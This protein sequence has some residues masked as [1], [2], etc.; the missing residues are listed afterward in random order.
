MAVDTV[1]RHV[2]RAVLKPFDVDIAG[3]KGGVLHRREGLDP[4]HALAVLAPEPLR[5]RDRSG[6][7]LI[8]A[9]RINV[10]VGGQVLGRRERV[11]YGCIR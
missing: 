7:H 11:V 4:I 9:R 6:V 10:G 8:I 2:E 1:G 3:R 5:V